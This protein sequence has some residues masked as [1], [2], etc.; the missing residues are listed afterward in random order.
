MKAWGIIALVVAGLYWLQAVL[1]PLALAVLAHVPLE[2]RREHAPPARAGSG[3][4][5]PRDGPPR[6]LD[7]GRD[8]L[9]AHSPGGDARGRP[10]AVQP[11]HPPQNCG[12]SRGQQGQLRGK[13][14]ES[15]GGRRRRDPEDRHAECD[16]SKAARR[17]P[18]IL[19]H[20]RP[21]AEPPSCAG[22]CGR[23]DG[24]RDLHVARAPG[25]PGSGDLADRLS[26]DDGDDESARRSRGAYQPVPAH[27][28]HRQRQL[29]RGRGTR[30][31]PDRG[32]L[33]RHLGVPGGGPSV[34]PVPG[35]IRR[36][37]PAARHQSGGVPGLARA[38]AGRRSVP[39]ASSPHRRPRPRR[40]TRRARSS[41]DREACST[42]TAS[43]PSPRHC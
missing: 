43:S 8:R 22:G 25:A 16:A 26:A 14:S 24:A 11:E 39:R 18:G 4:V 27:A 32:A 10:A 31:V 40:H 37:A 19:V 21:P 15:R 38:G 35:G 5:G 13:G 29:R 30:P 6:A 20:P 2:S 42:A 41:P 34:H 1:I 3:A 7:P 36:A 28:I 17:R 9:D 23:R 12:P 33:R